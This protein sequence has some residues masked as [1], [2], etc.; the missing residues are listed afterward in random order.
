MTRHRLGD[1]LSQLPWLGWVFCS[2]VPFFFYLFFFFNFFFVVVLPLPKSCPTLLN[3]G[4]RCQAVSGDATAN[5]WCHRKLFL[6]L[7]FL[8]KLNLFPVYCVY[9]Y[10]FCN[11]W[12]KFLYCGRGEWTVAITVNSRIM[13]HTFFFF[14]VMN[15]A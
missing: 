5:C 11:L 14:I 1:S 10:F 4:R 12:T 2:Y 8:Y 15:S 9:I 6:F 13:H 7:D 3:L